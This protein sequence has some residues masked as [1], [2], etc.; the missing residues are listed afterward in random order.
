MGENEMKTLPFVMFAMVAMAPAASLAGGQTDVLR[1]EALQLN[2]ESRFHTCLARCDRRA[3]KSESFDSVRCDE[4]CQTG[5]QAALDRINAKRVCVDPPAD[6]HLCE[7]KMLKVE[8]SHLVCESRCR[9]KGQR[10]DHF[11]VTQCLAGCD[12]VSATASDE[13]MRSPTCAA[14]RMASVS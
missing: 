2:R 3:E 14:G 1:C 7:A 4:S 13:T 5:L 11:D 10:S 8:A 9:K 6:V 12:E